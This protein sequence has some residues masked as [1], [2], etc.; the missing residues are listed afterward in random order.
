M[1]YLGSQAWQEKV[2]P[3]SKTTDYLLREMLGDQYLRLEDNAHDNGYSS[4][5]SSNI[6]K[7]DI[8]DEG[9]NLYLNQSTAIHA[10]IKSVL[11]EKYYNT[12]SVS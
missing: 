7:K 6:R 4:S 11:E 5:G 8:V 9:H 12:S 3:Y 10:F 1:Q 2:Q